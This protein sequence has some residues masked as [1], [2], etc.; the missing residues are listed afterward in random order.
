[1]KGRDAVSTPDNNVNTNDQNTGLT[2]GNLKLLKLLLSF[3]LF[4]YHFLTV[5]G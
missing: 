5:L 1:M 4:T 3:F 2:E